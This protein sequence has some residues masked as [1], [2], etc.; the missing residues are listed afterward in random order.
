MPIDVSA[1]LPNNLSRLDICAFIATFLFFVTEFRKDDCYSPECPKNIKPW[2]V[3]TYILFYSLQGLIVAFFKVKSRK[4][5]FFL[6]I[7]SSFVILP[8][9]LALNL[10]GNLLIEEM[11]NE[12]KC[13]YHGYAQSFQMLYLITT[14]CIV[15]VYLIFLITIKETMK[16]YYI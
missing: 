8:N 7:L 12:P 13:K 11:D 16:R 9:M 10:W 2:L 15:F 6:W 3:M 4:L 5:S 1:I 14:Y